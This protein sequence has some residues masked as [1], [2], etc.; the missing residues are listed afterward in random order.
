MLSGQIA[1]AIATVVVGQMI[2]TFGHFKIWHAG[3]SLLV[4]VSFSSVFGGCMACALLGNNYAVAHTIGYSAFAAIFNVGWAATQVSHMSLVNC[5]TS[6]QSSQVS[7]NSCRNAFTMAAN[8]GL[9]VIAYLVFRILPSKQVCDVETQFKWIAG[10]AIAVGICFVV[11]FQI[12]VKEPSLSHHKEGSQECNSRTSFKV[13]FGKLLY[14]Q[15]AAV[16]MLTRLTTN[17]SQALLPFYLIDDLLMEES[18]KAVVP[19]LI[20]ACSFLASI[21]LQELRWTSFQLKSVFTMGAALWV[22]SGATF[23]LLPQ[24]LHGPVYVLAVLIGVGN[25][26]M[27]VTAT[28]MEGVL[29]STNLSGCGFVY[30]SLSFLDKFACGIALYLIEGM[31]VQTRFC[32][33]ANVMG[34]SLLSFPPICHYSL[35]R[36]ALA[37]VPSGCAFLAWIITTTM[38]FDDSTLENSRTTLDDSLASLQTPLL[39]ATPAAEESDVTHMKRLQGGNSSTPCSI[40]ER[41]KSADSHG[42][43][44]LGSPG[45]DLVDSG[46]ESKEVTSRMQDEEAPSVWKMLGHAMVGRWGSIRPAQ[47]PFL[48]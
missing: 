6:N 9:Y 27:L 38:K 48:Q 35:I 26:F 33:T 34:Q 42:I 14:Y 24:S 30:G 22:L 5:I 39:H 1:D 47:L 46:I 3:G 32:P 2:D 13:W 15:V 36:V 12:G 28:S 31:N 7:L 4:A 21:V 29:V 41:R 17:V 44:D 8:L 25:A 16:Y 10:S 43:T 40:R 37:L 18:S 23:L 11:V 45:D 20:Y 19:A